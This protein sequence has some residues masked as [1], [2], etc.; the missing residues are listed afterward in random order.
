[1]LDFPK[2]STNASGQMFLLL[3][4]AGLRHVCRAGGSLI[5]SPVRGGIFVRAGLVPARIFIKENADRD[6]PCSYSFETNSI[7]SYLL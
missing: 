2:M 1:M 3:R 5:L 7:L 4:E 6:K